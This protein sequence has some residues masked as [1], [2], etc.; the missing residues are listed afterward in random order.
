MT[1]RRLLFL[2]LPLGWAWTPNVVAG[3][4][5]D[6][7]L[8][9]RTIQASAPAAE[10]SAG[11]GATTV[12]GALVL[13]AGGVWLLLRARAGKAGARGAQALAI[14]ETRPLGNRQFLVVASYE[15]QKFLLGVCPGRIDFLSPLNRD[16]SPVKAD[17]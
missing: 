2:L 9:P 16:G 8:V 12:I 11:A 4:D 5:A 6:Q 13:A 14:D 7:V 15:G 17:R 1:L 10:R 3:A